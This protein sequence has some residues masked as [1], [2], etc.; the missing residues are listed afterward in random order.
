MTSVKQ[1]IIFI[2]KVILGLLLYILLHF[3]LFTIYFDSFFNYSKIVDHEPK[4]CVISIGVFS[5][6][7]NLRVQHFFSILHLN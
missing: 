2:Y 3:T 7:I 1:Q 6:T 5:Y 4:I